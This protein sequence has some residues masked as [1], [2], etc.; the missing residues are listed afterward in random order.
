MIEVHSKPED[1][2]LEFTVSGTVTEADYRETLIPAVEAAIA[3]RDHV[4]LLARIG[5]N[6]ES[7]TLGA[8]ADDA[9]LGL[10]HWNGFDRAAVATDISWIRNATKAF[11]VFMPC[12]VATFALGEENDARRWL[13]ESLGTIHQTDLGN[14][15]LHVQLIGQLDAE[16]YARETE[17][18]D[19][20]I[21]AND[22][23][24]LLLDLR[25]FDGWQGLGALGEHFRLVR[26]H[27][28]LIDRAAFVGDKAWHRMAQRVGRRIINAPV[29]Y[30]PAEEFEGAK[31]WLL[32]E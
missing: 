1:A 24:R 19:A 12:P 25:Q 26:D 5:P 3:A 16:V 27:H 31:A 15:A 7:F 21:R 20:F 8:M 30:F 11:A 4:R 2:I 10:K 22:R 17:D 13:F 32:A 6:F 14:G 28:S 29:H 18:L 9:R 23:F